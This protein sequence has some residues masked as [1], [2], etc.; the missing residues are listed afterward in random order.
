[1]YMKGRRNIM[2]DQCLQ[3]HS[4]HQVPYLR[5]PRLLRHYHLSSDSEYIGNMI[6]LSS[7]PLPMSLRRTS[8]CN[9]GIPPDC[10]TFSHNI[11]QFVSYSNISLTHESFIVSLDYATLSKII[12]IPVQLACLVSHG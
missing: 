5:L 10:Y 7:P 9:T 3:C 1:M 4:C 8:R 11:A 6:Y 12:L 2:K